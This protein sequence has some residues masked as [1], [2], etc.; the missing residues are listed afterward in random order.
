MPIKTSSAGGEEQEVRVV[1]R[2]GPCFGVAVDRHQD[3]AYTL[4]ATPPGATLVA[5]DANSANATFG[6]QMALLTAGTNARM[7]DS[8][9]WCDA[10]G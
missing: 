8:T 9:P 10:G 1:R 2:Q 3:R 5:I 7:V 4:V 6:Q